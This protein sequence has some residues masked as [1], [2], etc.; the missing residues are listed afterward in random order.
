MWYGVFTVSKESRLSDKWKEDGKVVKFTVWSEEERNPRCH[1]LFYCRDYCTVAVASSILIVRSHKR[2]PPQAH[3]QTNASNNGRGYLCI[4]LC[5]LQ[6]GV[7]GLRA[8]TEVMRR[9]VFYFFLV[10]RWLT[11]FHMLHFRWREKCLTCHKINTFS[12]SKKKKK[13]LRDFCLLMPLVAILNSWIQ[14]GEVAPDWELQ[15]KRLT[16][17]MMC[18]TFEHK[19]N[20]PLTPSLFWQFCWQHVNVSERRVIK[21]ALQIATQIVAYFECVGDLVWKEN[22]MLCKGTLKGQQV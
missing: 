14:V 13:L 21:E 15:L 9:V 18:Q 12:V 8:S 20:A 1:W 4:C 16:W 2:T 6:H 19:W 7:C 11:V 10:N 3:A 5:Y 17:N 22:G